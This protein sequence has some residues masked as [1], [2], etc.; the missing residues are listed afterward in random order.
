M[1]VMAQAGRRHS[2]MNKN[3]GDSD[4]P[5]TRSSARYEIEKTSGDEELDHAARGAYTAWVF[6]SSVHCCAAINPSNTY[7]LTLS[8]QT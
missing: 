2:K 8:L 1:N 4:G 6:V 5:D 7:N 3:D